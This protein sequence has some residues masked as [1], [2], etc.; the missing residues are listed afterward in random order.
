MPVISAPEDYSICNTDGVAP[1]MLTATWTD[2]CADGGSVDAYPVIFSQ[3]DCITVYAYEFNVE[4]A[5][6]NTATA[7]TYIT[8][9]I[10]KYDNCET[11]YAK[12]DND[13]AHCFIGDY[14]FNRWGWTNLI[15]QPGQYTLPIYAGAAQCDTDKGALVGQVIVDYIGTT[16]TI[17]YQIDEGYVMSQ[18]HIYVGCEPYPTKNGT[19]TVAPGQYTFNDGD[20]DHVSGLIAEFNKVKGA[21]YIIAHAVT[22]EAVCQCTLPDEQIAQGYEPMDLSIDCAPVVEEATA[23][24]NESFSKASGNTVDNNLLQTMMNVKAFPNPFT[25]TVKFEFTADRDGEATLDIFNARG[26]KVATVFRQ[27]VVKG[28]RVDHDYT[29]EPEHNATGNYFYRFTLNGYSQKGVL[30]Y[31]KTK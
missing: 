20:L 11:A 21:F 9:G 14:N 1:E 29:P 2:N 17:E 26:I 19:P 5:C 6:G 7:T 4:D 16:V 8:V 18:A 28:Q 15:E 30:I 3:D 10:D 27:N 13:N 23:G 31:H 22:C 24:N 12:L 25:H